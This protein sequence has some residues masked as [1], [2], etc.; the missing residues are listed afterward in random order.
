M[1]ALIR[2]LQDRLPVTGDDIQPMT[3][4]PVPK[5]MERWWF[6]LGGTPAYLFVIQIITGILLTIY[7]KPSPDT[8]YESVRFITEE[9][10]FGW[11]IRGLHKWAATLMIAAVILH[12]MRVYF[13]GAYRKPRELNWMVGMMMLLCTLLIG[14][15]GY[16]LVFEQLSY[17]GATVGANIADAVPFVGGFFKTMLLGG[18]VYNDNTLPRS[19]IL[20]AAVLPVTLTLLSIVHIM[21]IRLQGVTEFQFEEDKDK[22]PQHFSFWP[23]HVMSE[24][25]MGLVLMIILSVLATV[26]PA[27]SDPKPIR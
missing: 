1:S 5:H 22:P 19:F 11:Y 14:F 4:E 26:V 9:A 13:T 3:N 17:W 23:D 24:L 8:A 6:A 15:T 21:I 18:E 10:A 7:Y 16:S 25:A 2:W 27:D 12:Q 20:H